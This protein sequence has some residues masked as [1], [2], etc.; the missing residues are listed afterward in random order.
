MVDRLGCQY[1]LSYQVARTSSMLMGNISLA[2]VHGVRT[3]NP[4]FTLSRTIQL[5]N[6]YHVPSINKIPSADLFY[7]KMVLSWF[8]SP[9]KL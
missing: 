5:K 9:I 6:V 7:I 8:F 3:T 4:R 2:F 1:V